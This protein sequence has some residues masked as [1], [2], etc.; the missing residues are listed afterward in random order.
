MT[1]SSLPIEKIPGKSDHP[2]QPPD[3][4]KGRGAGMSLSSMCDTLDNA[5][6]GAR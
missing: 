6:A 4:R 1:I 5:S 3:R 2:D